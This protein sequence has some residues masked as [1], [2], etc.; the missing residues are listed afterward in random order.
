MSAFP[1]EP[2]TEWYHTQHPVSQQHFTV[3]VSY[4]IWFSAVKSGA[5]CTLLL[6]LVIQRVKSSKHLLVP[7]SYILSIYDRKLFKDNDCSYTDILIHLFHSPVCFISLH[8]LTSKCVF[9]KKDKRTPQNGLQKRDCEHGGRTQVSNLA[10]RHYQPLGR[11]IQVFFQ[12][13]NI[14]IVILKYQLDKIYDS[15]KG[16]FKVASFSSTA[17]LLA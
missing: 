7:Y 14:L 5:A 10:Q 8:C 12:H 2:S 4:F 1:L 11:D 6:T 3:F 15:H 9:H 16:M 17:I 13:W